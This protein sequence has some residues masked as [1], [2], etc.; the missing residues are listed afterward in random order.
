MYHTPYIF[1]LLFIKLFSYLPG[2]IEGYSLW[3]KSYTNNY[4]ICID[5]YMARFKGM[6]RPEGECPGILQCC[7]DNSKVGTILEINPYVESELEITI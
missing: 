6:W 2:T 4:G 7:A 1:N 5:C 3:V